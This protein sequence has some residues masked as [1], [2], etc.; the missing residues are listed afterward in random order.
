MKAL[1]NDNPLD[2][3]LQSRIEDYF[4]Y[5]WNF[6]RNLACSTE[7]D[8]SIMEQLPE[9]VQDRIYTKF[10]Y[11]SFLLKFQLFFRIPVEDSGAS[12]H[13]GMFYT[14]DNNNY[15]E[16]LML[17]LNSM[18]PLRFDRGD[19]IFDHETEV[20]EVDFIEQGNVDIG[21]AVSRGTK[22]ALRLFDSSVLGAYHC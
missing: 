7:E 10:L 3:E 6:D 14:L 21:F 4:E 16:F 2:R 17:L 11:R 8:R 12:E 15:R 9:F 1:N 19:T 18:S 20:N 22:Y 5:K 13:K